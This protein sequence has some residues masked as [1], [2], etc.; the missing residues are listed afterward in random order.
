MDSLFFARFPTI[1]I[2]WAWLIFSIVILFIMIFNGW[3]KRK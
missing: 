3:K 1:W 2:A